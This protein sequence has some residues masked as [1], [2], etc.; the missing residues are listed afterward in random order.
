MRV[1]GWCFLIVLVLIF[2]PVTFPFI[3]ALL[4][5]SAA[6]A[7]LKPE[8]FMGAILGI[9]FLAWYARDAKSRRLKREAVD[10]ERAKAKARLAIER[11]FG[12]ATVAQR[13]QPLAAPPPAPSPTA[14]PAL[15]VAQPL[16]MPA[17]HNSSASTSGVIV[18]AILLSLAA[19]GGLGFMAARDLCLNGSMNPRHCTLSDWC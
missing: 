6:F 4:G 5:G 8:Y 2:W 13:A 11:E 7:A 16:A 18:A 15:E 17:L 14:A 19:G 9:A 1:L 3:A 10:I 12:I